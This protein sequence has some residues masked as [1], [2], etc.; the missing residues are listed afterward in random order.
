MDELERRIHLLMWVRALPDDVDQKP[1]GMVKLVRHMLADMDALAEMMDRLEDKQ[2][3]RYPTFGELMHHERTQT[4]T[5]EML[6]QAIAWLT[7]TEGY[8]HLT[9]EEVYAMLVE[10][11]EAVQ[12]PP[13]G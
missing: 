3:N 1:A 8:T 9:P 4:P 12:S 13:V 10:Q 6:V 5:E 11:T 7:T 2:M